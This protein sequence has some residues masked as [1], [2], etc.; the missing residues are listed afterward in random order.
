MANRPTSKLEIKA[1][2]FAQDK[3]KGQVRKFV[4]KS[5]FDAHVQKV[6]G[7]VKFYTTSVVILCSALLHDVIEDCY[8]DKWVGYNETKE[9]FGKEI[10]DIVLELTS[11]SDEI[12]YKW[13][14]DKAAYLIN[15][16]LNM[17]D[18]A[19]TIKLG[20]RLQNISDAFT[21]S[22]KFRNNYFA[23]TTKILNSL[24]SSGRNFN[25]S[26]RR[27]MA[28]IKAKLKNVKSIFKIE[29]FNSF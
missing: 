8:D 5:Y 24:E 26:H 2:E 18:A 9:I 14:G 25:D 10:A 21:A 27:L 23:E 1:W 7:I 19:L 4:N 17:S 28:D 6:N 11:N 20:D 3:H 12:K 13:N 15:K 29:K 22:E 16:M